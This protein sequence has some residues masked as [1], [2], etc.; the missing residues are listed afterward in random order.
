VRRLVVLLG[1]L[2]L[3]AAFSPERAG[4]GRGAVLVP[5][6]KLRRRRER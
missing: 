5:G 2:G 4:R 3:L 6:L 1:V